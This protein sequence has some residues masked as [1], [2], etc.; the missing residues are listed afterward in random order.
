MAAQFDQAPAKAAAIAGAWLATRCLAPA[1]SAMSIQ[2][3]DTSTPTKRGSTGRAACA[4]RVEER[5][6]A[7][8]RLPST[9]PPAT[10]CDA[11]WVEP[12]G[13]WTTGP[14]ARKVRSS[15]TGL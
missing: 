12:G 1:V 3:F 13:V 7:R 14:F 15:G 5:G 8:R 2:D 4:R 11:F 6:L 9:L 10:A